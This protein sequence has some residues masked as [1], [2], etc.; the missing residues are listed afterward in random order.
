MPAAEVPA[1][2]VPAAEVVLAVVVIC[3]AGRV[4]PPLVLHPPLPGVGDSGVPLGLGVP[5]DGGDAGGGEV[6]VLP[7]APPEQSFNIC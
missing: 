6:D 4:N 7:S 5:L 3:C 1:A 2:E